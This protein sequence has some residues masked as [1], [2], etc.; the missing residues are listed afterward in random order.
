[1]IER[2]SKNSTLIFKKYFLSDLLPTSLA[3][4]NRLEAGSDVI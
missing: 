1:M 4:N 2:L 3:G